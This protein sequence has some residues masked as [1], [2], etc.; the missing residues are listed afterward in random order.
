MQ[1][2][3]GGN[4]RFPS[5]LIDSVRTFFPVEAPPLV[6]SVSPVSTTTGPDVTLLT[7]LVCRENLNHCY[8]SEFL[9]LSSLTL[10]LGRFGLEKENGPVHDE[11]GILR[12]PSEVL[13]LRTQRI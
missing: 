3:S 8:S 2:L 6:T 9:H 11:K 13:R 10:R 4:P 5:A 12:R 7:S 1:N